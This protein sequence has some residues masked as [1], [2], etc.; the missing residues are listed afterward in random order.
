ML[1]KQ[2]EVYCSLLSAFRNYTMWALGFFYVSYLSNPIILDL[3]LTERDERKVPATL[4]LIK[5][6]AILIF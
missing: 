2:L 4:L 5:L 6:I 3:K 1:A